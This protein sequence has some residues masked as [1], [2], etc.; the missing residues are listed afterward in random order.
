MLLMG[1]GSLLYG[2]RK[3]KMLRYLLLALYI[4]AIFLTGK[5]TISLISITLPILISVLKTPSKKYIWTLILLSAFSFAIYYFINNANTY[6]YIPGLGRIA[7]TVVDASNG[8]DVDS[9]RNAL[10]VKALEGYRQ[11]SLLGIGI[12]N[13]PTWSGMGMAVHNMYLQ[14]LC[15]QG[16]I[17]FL[18]FIIPLVL[19]LVKCI[20]SLRNCSDDKDIL[21]LKLILWV[22]FYFIIYGFTGNPTVNINGFILYF[23][24]IMMYN[25]YIVKNR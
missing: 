21:S 4:I 17:G 25:N 1:E 12:G 18:L 11:N 3:N 16:I 8:I 2:E 22:Q 5:R 13:F 14:T 10:F 23:Y 15:E 6:L 9:G 7:Q 24:S 19:C 20:A